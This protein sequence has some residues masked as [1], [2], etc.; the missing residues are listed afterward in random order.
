M[1]KTLFFILST[2]IF[3]GCS[4]IKVTNDFD[5]AFSF[6]DVQTYAIVH[7]SQDYGDT[8]TDERIK[9]GINTQLKRKGYTKA[10]RQNADIYVVFHTNVQNKTKIVQDYQYIGISPYR[11]GRSYGY[12]GM[13]AVPVSRTY[14]YDEGKLIIDILNAKEKKIVWRGIA[15]DSLKDHK[16]PEKRIEYINEVMISIF[17]TLP[18]KILSPK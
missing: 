7:K 1:T 6:N 11:Y 10:K 16:T 18:S 17:K 2:L 5:P 14:N 12:G 15:T 8:L 9:S 3:S 13:M 4:S